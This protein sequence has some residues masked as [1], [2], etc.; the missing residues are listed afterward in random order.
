MGNNNR[1]SALWRVN[2]VAFSFLVL[3]AITGLIDW[4]LP[5]GGYRPGLNGLCTIRHFLLEVHLWVALLFVISIVV[6]GVLHWSYIRTNLRRH[7]L[8]N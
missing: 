8:S 3:L 1:S 2:I 6:H 4:L 5:R 7:G